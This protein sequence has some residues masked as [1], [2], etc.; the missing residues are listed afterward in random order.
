[1][2]IG[3]KGT[4]CAEILLVVWGVALMRNFTINFLCFMQYDYLNY[5]RYIY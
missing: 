2:H 5:V 3:K 4:E 1:M